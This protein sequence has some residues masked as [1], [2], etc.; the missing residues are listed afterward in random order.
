VY[1]GGSR[2]IF[3]KKREHFSWWGELPKERA[4]LIGRAG[5]EI[6]KSG[7]LKKSR[8]RGKHKNAQEKKRIAEKVN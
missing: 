5:T 7:R 8:L 2:E 6:R 1:K 4:N 3:Q